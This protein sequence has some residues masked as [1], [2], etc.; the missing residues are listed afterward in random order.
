MVVGPV[1]DQLLH[2]PSQPRGRRAGA[3]LS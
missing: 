2:A 1:L 3:E